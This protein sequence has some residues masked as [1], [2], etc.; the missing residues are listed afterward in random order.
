MKKELIKLA[1]HSDR[2]GLTKEAD[3][4]DTLLKKAFKF[5]TDFDIKKFIER[6]T[7][8]DPDKK[9]QREIVIS[10]YK[11]LEQEARPY[12]ITYNYYLSD[13]ID[14]IKEEAGA[15]CLLCRGNLSLKEDKIVDDWLEA[16]REF[17][18]SPYH[19]ED[20]ELKKIMIGEFSSDSN[21]T[22]TVI[23]IKNYA[24]KKYCHFKSRQ[25]HNSIVYFGEE[26]PIITKIYC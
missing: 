3:F 12:E 15:H 18:S 16:E 7:D 22:D 24:T 26:D 6:D 11:D 5:D 1:N 4:V 8:I 25:G 14:L 9:D 23:T 13:D 17:L 10:V 2:I 20:P 21:K 19:P